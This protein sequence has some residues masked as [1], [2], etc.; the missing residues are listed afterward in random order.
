MS[1]VL[2]GLDV[3][4]TALKVAAVH[5]RTGSC[6]AIAEQVLAARLSPDGTREQKVNEIR[7]AVLAGI[8]QVV[9]ALGPKDRVA[10]IGLSAQ[11][12]SGAV[13]DRSTGRPRT[14][15]YLWNDLRFMPHL[16]AIEA[17]KSSNWWRQL[18]RR[19]GPGWGLGRIDWL[20]KTRPTAFTGDTMYV[21]VGELVFHMLTGQWVQDA[22]NALQQGCFRVSTRRIDREALGL[23]GVGE[24]FVAELRMADRS[25]RLTA[26][27]MG[28]ELGI[29]VV[30]PYMDHES[31]WRACSANAR[32]LQVS[33]GTAWVAN[34]AMPRTAK[35]SSPFQLVVPSP[36][37]D[38]DDLVIQPLL[39]G[40][41]TWDWVWRDLLGARDAADGA[42]R[43]WGPAGRNV[44]PPAG[45]IALPWL[46]MPS[47]TH[48]SRTGAG[49]LWGL[50]P[51]TSREEMAR[52]FAAGMAHEL[53]R[54][55]ADVIADGSRTVV[56]TGGASKANGWRRLVAMALGK[57]R[58]VQDGS[59]TG[60]RG[61]IASLSP[62]A[63]HVR[64]GPQI[65]VSPREQ[66]DFNN[67]HE[68][69][70]ALFQKLYGSV[71]VGG[72]FTLNP[73]ARRRSH[74]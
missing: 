24:S 68:R 30:G 23:V 37:R 39:T 65:R 17:K 2:I 11:G 63:G 59:I 33:L 43:V 40:N 12:G 7:M 25:H 64:P 56:L 6:L 66:T 57:V 69:Y 53:R 18:G 15:M 14:P 60:C 52:A 27:I 62:A 5:A 34:F 32:V 45:L 70:L 36:T 49:A 28:I 1:D 21:G 13:V 55:L 67:D 73:S 31:A 44:L 41:I 29:P 20:K 35:Y 3:G 74:S 46:N 8:E 47:P 71:E 58:C 16:P 50:S 51:T 38:D 54:V 10:G 72:R 4:T 48:P 26:R 61:A 9:G 22:C 19:E 42:A